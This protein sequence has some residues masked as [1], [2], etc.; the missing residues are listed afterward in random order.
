[1]PRTPKLSYRINGGALTNIATHGFHLVKSDDR[2]TAPIKPYEEQR[3]P[4]SSASE[5][6]PHT[7]K[8]TFD[9]TVEILALGDYNTVNATVKSFWDSMFNGT[10]AHP[11]TLYNYWKGVQVTGYP[12]SADPSASYPRL[13]EYEKSA[14]IFK[15]TLYVADPETLILL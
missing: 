3:Y 6:Y 14:Y 5:I 12:K 10:Q 8:D 11:I 2:I 15:L 13:A 7:V 1:M 4:E 9:Y